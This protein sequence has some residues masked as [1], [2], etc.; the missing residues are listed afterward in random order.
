ME[1]DEGRKGLDAALRNGEGAI[2]LQ[3]YRVGGNWEE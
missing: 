1:K 3:G 2:G